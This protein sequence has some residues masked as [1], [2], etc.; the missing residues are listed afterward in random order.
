[1]IDTKKPEQIAAELALQAQIQEA[2]ETALNEKIK[3]AGIL[4]F[5][6]EREVYRPLL[7]AVN[8]PEIGVRSALEICVDEE[9]QEYL[10]Q[11]CIGTVIEKL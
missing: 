9:A 1:M 10:V 8:I 2:E 11:H 5:V 3:N 7:M 4:H 6:K